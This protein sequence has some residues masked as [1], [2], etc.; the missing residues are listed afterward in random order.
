MKAL[1]FADIDGTLIDQNNYCYEESL[2]GINLLQENSIPLISVSS[3]TFDEMSLLVREL[4]LN[5]PFA[6][7]NGTGIAYPSETGED[8]KLE[9]EGPGI[10]KLSEFLPELERLSGRSLKGII[11]LSDNEI[12]DL[13]GLDLKKAALAKKRMTTLPF[14]ADG[15]NLLKDTEISDLNAV[16]TDY[17]FHITKGGRFNHL[18]P[19]CT[20]K[21]YA[22]KKI[23]EFYK[24]KYKDEIITAAAGDSLN[25]IPM[26]EAVD[27]SY[28]I[29]KSG[30]SF[31][32]F[33]SGKIMNSEGPAGFSEAVINFLKITAG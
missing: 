30:G 28:V 15:D 8:F 31:I 19:A 1:F 20:G 13:T 5:H 16:L 22:V 7:E 23:I 25:D 33:M 17:N 9:L 14:I 6:F 3:K 11:T 18:L 26:L 12:K 10:E 4:N 21:G 24:Y 2:H 29:R 32:N 27:Y